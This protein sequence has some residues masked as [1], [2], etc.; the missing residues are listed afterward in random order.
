[1]NDPT[2]WN[3]L[4]ELRLESAID[5][6]LGKLSEEESIDFPWLNKA[7]QTRMA[8]AAVAVLEAVTYNAMWLEQMGGLDP[9]W[10]P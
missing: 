2:S 8:K 7:V 4:L 3:T 5:D 6:I 1:M 9:K 10:V